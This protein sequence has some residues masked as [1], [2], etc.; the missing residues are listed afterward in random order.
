MRWCDRGNFSLRGKDSAELC[1][2]Q[3]E[4][5]YEFKIKIMNSCMRFYLHIERNIPETRKLERVFSRENSFFIQCKD[6]YEV[7]GIK[8]HEILCLSLGNLRMRKL[9]KDA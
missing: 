9:Y 7:V 5:N 4:L 8:G 3:L 6:S 2:L 1:I